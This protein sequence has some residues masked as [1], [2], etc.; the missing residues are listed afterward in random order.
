VSL[1]LLVYE[2]KRSDWNDIRTGINP[3]LK[4]I[5]LA[6]GTYWT[7]IDRVWVVKAASAEQLWEE[8]KPCFGNEDS[9]LILEVQPGSTRQ[10]WLDKKAWDWFDSA[11]GER[12]AEGMFQSTTVK[13][14]QPAQPEPPRPKSQE[15]VLEWSDEEVTPAKQVTPDTTVLTCGFCGVEAPTVEWTQNMCPQCGIAR[16]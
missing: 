9:V 16:G 1:F 15:K 6:K 10:G 7:H 4:T 8:V 11:V 13:Y 2:P 5:L 12:K 14:T 3:R